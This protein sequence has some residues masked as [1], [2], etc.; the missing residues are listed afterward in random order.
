LEDLTKLK[1]IGPTLAQ[2]LQGIGVESL[3]D[4]KKLGSIE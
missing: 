3:E 4:L 2:K 1:N